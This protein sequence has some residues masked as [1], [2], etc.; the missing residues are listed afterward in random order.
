[1]L[2]T[3][4]LA[5]IFSFSRVHMKLVCLHVGGAARYVIVTGLINNIIQINNFVHML[6]YSKYMSR[7]MSVM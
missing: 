4:E 5:E 1:M 2:S 6:F 3:F 7:L